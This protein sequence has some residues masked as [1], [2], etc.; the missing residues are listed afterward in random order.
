MSCDLGF[1]ERYAALRHAELLDE[2]ERD[3][4][5]DEA[6][7]PVPSLRLRLAGLLRSTA[8]RLEGAP[9]QPVYEVRVA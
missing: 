2:V 6:R 1:I 5:A 8:E 7:G 4:L 3:R 9:A